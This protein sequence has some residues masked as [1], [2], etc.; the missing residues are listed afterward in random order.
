MEI[1]VGN[2][3][4]I[5]PSLPCSEI[6]A[7]AGDTVLLEGDIVVAVVTRDTRRTVDK[8]FPAK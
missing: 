6:F 5:E 7:P 4:D 8:I 2:F 3:E 1:R